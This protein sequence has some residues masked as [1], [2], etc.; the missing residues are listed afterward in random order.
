[1]NSEGKCNKPEDCRTCDN[2]CCHGCGYNAG[3]TRG[4]FAHKTGRYWLN[5][6]CGEYC[7]SFFPKGD[8]NY[9]LPT[10]ADDK[11]KDL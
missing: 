8:F 5:G 4:C 1:M 11:T 9:D 3:C 2:I 7:Q 6:M 10:W